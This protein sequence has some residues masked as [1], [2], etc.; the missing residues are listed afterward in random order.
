MALFFVIRVLW[1]KQQVNSKFTIV[2]VSISSLLTYRLMMG[3][4]YS[5]V[6]ARIVLS[7]FKKKNDCRS[8]LQSFYEDERW[9][10]IWGLLYMYMYM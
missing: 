8:V 1:R 2:L 5:Q 9:T 3:F 7:S 6:M 4:N 10:F